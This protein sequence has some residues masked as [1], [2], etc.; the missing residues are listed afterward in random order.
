M[1]YVQGTS[2]ILI[3]TPLGADKVLLKSFQGEER[4]SE[5]FHFTLELWS[6][7]NAIDFTQIVG[8]SVT[9]TISLA[10]GDKQYLNGIV[11]RFV[12]AGTADA[13]FTTYYAEVHPL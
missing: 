7:D 9:I 4:I 1:S 10:S 6:Q 8:K 13:R 2:P 12:Q 5:P 3:S 11:G